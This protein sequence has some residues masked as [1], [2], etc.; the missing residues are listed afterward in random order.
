MQ[1]QNYEKT[2]S[3][4]QINIC[5]QK[6]NIFKNFRH[7]LIKMIESYLL[8]SIERNGKKMEQSV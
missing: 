8:V 4:V 6:K 7:L 3:L 1:V 2:Q 5:V